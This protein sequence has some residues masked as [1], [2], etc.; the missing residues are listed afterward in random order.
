MVSSLASQC[1]QNLVQPLIDDAAARVISRTSELI[2]G[3]FVAENFVN[4]V[5]A[6]LVPDIARKAQCEATVDSYRQWSD[7]TLASAID[8]I[9]R[10]E[11]CTQIVIV[12]EIQ[13]L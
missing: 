11:V 8:K 10:E 13:A 12:H 5:V 9:A 7:A 4:K 2:V 3:G 6:G 1:Y